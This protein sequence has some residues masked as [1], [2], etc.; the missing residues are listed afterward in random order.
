MS[1]DPAA[2][3]PDMLLDDAIDKIEGDMELNQSLSS[4]DRIK[5]I[6]NIIETY[7]SKITSDAYEK[8]KQIIEY[9]KTELYLPPSERTGSDED[10]QIS[11]GDI[12]YHFSKKVH[13]IARTAYD[14]DPSMPGGTRAY[15][16]KFSRCVK[17]VR[18]RIKP[19]RGSNKESAAIAI[20]TKSVLQT[21]GRTM[22][23]YRKGKLIT[24]KF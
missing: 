17:T 2:V 3:Q 13:A 16:K 6:E 5:K 21:R 15:R 10:Y 8:L 9:Y 7:K 19:R 1:E 4:S 20:C 12:L 11:D 22:K 24:Q 23:K 18:R 14:S